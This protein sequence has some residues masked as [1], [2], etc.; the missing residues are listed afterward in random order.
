M[1]N[2]KLADGGFVVTINNIP[3]YFRHLA[4]AMNYISMRGASR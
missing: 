1:V 4:A 2:L 3:H